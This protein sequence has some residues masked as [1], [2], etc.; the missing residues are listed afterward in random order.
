MY[1]SEDYYGDKSR[2]M[3]RI[4]NEQSIANLIAI[5][6]TPAVFGRLSDDTKEN[7]IR[8]LG[9]YAKKTADA[10]LISSNQDAQAIREAARGNQL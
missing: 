4:N 2:L 9:G 10:I 7:I 3:V 8:V 6:N 1:G 5:F